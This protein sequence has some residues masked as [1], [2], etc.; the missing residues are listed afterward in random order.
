MVVI[1]MR[2]IV[3][4]LVVLMVLGSGCLGNNS[5]KMKTPG[6]SQTESPTTTLSS[7]TPVSL[8]E[9]SLDSSLLAI[10]RISPSAPLC[11]VDPGEAISQFIEALRDDY[12]LKPTEPDFS[13]PEDS[14]ASEVFEISEVSG[15]Y[16]GVLRIQTITQPLG[17]WKSSKKSLISKQTPQT[18]SSGKEKGRTPFTRHFRCISEGS[19]S[20]SSLKFHTAKI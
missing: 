15:A 4:I 5:V 10:E 2:K 12:S 1:T 20:L 13:V 8:R 18:D 6:T 17:H 14:L 3:G 16:V 7:T 9:E 19:T 11:G